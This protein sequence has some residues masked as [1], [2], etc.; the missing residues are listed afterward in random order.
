MR[1]PEPGRLYDPDFLHGCT[2]PRI[3]L[4]LPY[5]YGWFLLALVAI[6]NGIVREKT[7]G[8]RLAE[9]DAHQLSTLLAAIAVSAVTALLHLAWPLPDRATALRVGLTWLVMTVAFEC[10]FGHVVA[11]HPWRRLW[12]D[13][14]L[15]AGR[16]WSLFLA[17]LAALPTLLFLATGPAD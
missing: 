15:R 2:P 1:C 12:A 13:Y 14:D 11:G 3:S 16:V 6:V 4:P 5:L 9:R 10:L 8:R 17:W 7:Y